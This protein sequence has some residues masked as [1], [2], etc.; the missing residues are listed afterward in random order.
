MTDIKNRAS[1][2]SEKDQLAMGKLPRTHRNMIEK[3][4]K[5]RAGKTAM[6]RARNSK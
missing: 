3:T 2:M 5:A 4:G 6:D 1:F